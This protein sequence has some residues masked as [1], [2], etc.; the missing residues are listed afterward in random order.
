MQHHYSSLLPAEEEE[1]EVV[2]DEELPSSSLIT[3]SSHYFEKN[4]KKFLSTTSISSSTIWQ[5]NYCGLYAQYAAVGLI[6]GSMNVSYNFCV[7]YYDGPSNLCANAKN[8][9]MLAWR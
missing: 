1:Q 2:S 9:Q 4:S 6:C 8:I 3:S 5:W 7:Y